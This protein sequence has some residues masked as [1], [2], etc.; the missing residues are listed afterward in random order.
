MRGICDVSLC[1]AEQSAL[2]PEPRPH[3]AEQS[4]ADDWRPVWPLREEVGMPP[5]CGA[6]GPSGR[7]QCS[8][9][10]RWPHSRP[11]LSNVDGAASVPG[12]Q[13]AQCALRDRL[14]RAGQGRAG[15]ACLSPALRL[16]GAPRARDGGTVV[17]K[18]VG[19]SL[20]CEHSVSRDRCR[21]LGTLTQ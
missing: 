1:K 11:Q 16:P 12:G 15:L 7:G 6:P 20:Q 5:P 18:A 19:Y 10:L 13:G 4:R 21:P 17:Q 3:R 14:A 8:R 2:F 9:G